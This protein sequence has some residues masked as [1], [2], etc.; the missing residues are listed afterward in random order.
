MATD[1]TKGFILM[2]E[3]WLHDNINSSAANGVRWLT[4][5]DSGTAFGVND[6]AELQA[7]GVTG[8][9]NDNY[10]EIAHRLTWRAQD[11]MMSMEA[12][13]DLTDITAVGTFIGFSDNVAENQLP[14][15]LSGTTFTAQANTALGFVFCTDATNDNWHVTMVDDTNLT[16]VP[17]ASLNTGVAPVNN[18]PQTFKVVVYD[19]EVCNQTRSE[20]WIDGELQLTMASSIDRDALLTPY[21]GHVTRSCN[22]RT[23]NIHY[24]TTKQTRP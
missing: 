6:S 17:I 14:V 19:Q 2:H 12:R 13:V 4:T 18:T 23:M 11:G 7:Q 8:S 22:T 20:F 24:I 16:T 21:I 3:E 15:A 9:A 5:T 10:N 1:T